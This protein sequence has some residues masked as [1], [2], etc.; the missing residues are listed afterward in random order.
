MKNERFL[1]M[2]LKESL[3]K[4]FEL[5]GCCA[6]WE[7]WQSSKFEVLF[8]SFSFKKKKV[9]KKKGAQSGAFLRKMKRDP[10]AGHFEGEGS[11]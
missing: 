9:K 2:V 4:N 3:S 10:E 8:A 11:P 7:A 1:H 6:L 5:G